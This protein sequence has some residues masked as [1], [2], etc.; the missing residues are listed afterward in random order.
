MSFAIAVFALERCVTGYIEG[1][2]RLS[3][4]LDHFHLSHHAHVLAFFRT[5]LP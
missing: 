2:V 4:G 5:E 1:G 3:D